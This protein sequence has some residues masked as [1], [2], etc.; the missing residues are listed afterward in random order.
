MKKERFKEIIN[1]YSSTSDDVKSLKKLVTA[2]PFSQIIHLL[3]ANASKE[4]DSTDYK[5]SLSNA[6]FHS[7]DRS[8]LKS[9]IEHNLVPSEK[10]I[11]VATVNKSEAKKILTPNSP[12]KRTQAVTRV[13]DPDKLI[14]EVLENLEK[15]QQTK[16]ET[17]ILFEDT[18]SINTKKKSTP[19]KVVSKPKIKKK[20]SKVKSQTKIIEKFIKDE[21]R[22]TKNASPVND[23]ADM[24]SS[25][26]KMRDDVISESL[27][28]IF[29][30]QGKNVKAI[31][32]YK[33]LIWKFPQKKAFFATQ[34]E[35]LKKK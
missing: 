15:L 23:K 13:V 1:N 20:T 6:A 14:N 29:V 7:T 4:T 16:K 28:K 26:G 24:A 10:L 33:K 35:K 27:A 18:P 19:S 8:I 30:K 32:I 34:I 25:S 31:D 12:P 22:I 5:P 17:A 3:L 21:P 9:L 2:Y 11:S